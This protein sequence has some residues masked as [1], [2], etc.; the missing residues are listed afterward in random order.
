MSSIDYN[1]LASDSLEDIPPDRETCTA[2]LTDPNIQIRRLVDAAFE[3]RRTYF[4]RKVQIHI[5]NNAQNGHCP[6]DCGYCAQARTSD[7]A[8]ADYPIKND[9]EILAEARSAYESGAFRYC[10]VFAGRGPSKRRVERLCGLITKIKQ[11]YPIQV[12]LSPGLLDREDTA[13]LKAAGLDRL[14][15]NLN[16]SEARYPSIC[17]TH[18]YQDR[19]HTLEAANQSGLEL[20]S[21]MICGMGETPDEISG[22]AHTL[23]ELGVSSIP[24]NFLIPIAGNAVSQA[25]GLTPDYC[26]RILCMYRLVNPRSE[27]R[28]AAGRET[29]LGDLE[30][31]ALHAA[32]SLFMDGYLNTRGSSRVRTLQMIADAGFTVDSDHALDNLLAEE[33]R[34]ASPDELEAKPEDLKSREQLRSFAS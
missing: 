34:A 5:I 22:I 6:E 28:M 16:T 17:T 24:V 1:K 9:D 32:N 26:L 12:C 25:T 20:C 10:M 27:I 4:G 15:H 8:I 21:G 23:R 19:I 30:P 11:A 29:H 7:A 14:N 31:L 33:T 3:V 13:N 2:L 18:T